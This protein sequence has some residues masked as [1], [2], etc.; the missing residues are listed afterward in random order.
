MSHQLAE[1]HP[2]LRESDL[3]REAVAQIRPFLTSKRIEALDDVTI[4]LG[5][6]AVKVVVPKSVLD[7]LLEALTVMSTGDAVTVLP[8]ESELTTQQAA[9]ILNVSRPHMVKLLED[10]EIAYRSVGT[11]RRV[12]AKALIEYRD[13][14]NKHRRSVADKLTALAQEMDLA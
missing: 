4:T 10:G 5:G 14:D 6:S 12:L 7:L 8:T 9:D 13:T 3:A 2:N 11:H 1:L